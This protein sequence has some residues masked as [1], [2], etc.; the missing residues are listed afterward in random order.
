MSQPQPDGLFPV[1]GLPAPALPAA[2][3][4][5]DDQQERWQRGE[6]VLVEDYLKQWPALE[7]DV[8]RTLDLIYQEFWLRVTRGERPEPDE[9]LKRFPHWADQLRLQFQVHGAVHPETQSSTVPAENL[10]AL[11]PQAAVLPAVPGYEVLEELGKGGMG[12]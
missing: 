12:V 2:G 10:F 7:S 8:E 9:Y 11:G 3:W 1:E 6:R 4:L 5:L